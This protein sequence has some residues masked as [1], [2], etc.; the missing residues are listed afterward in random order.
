[1]PEL[2]ES[3]TALGVAWMRALHQVLDS[4]PLILEDEPIVKL[5]GRDH[6]ERASKATE[7]FQASGARMLR[8]HVVLRSRFTEDR[9]EQALGRGEL[10]NAR[11]FAG[12]ADALPP[13]RKTSLL[14]AIV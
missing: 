2:K 9:L 5:L 1:M 7:R 11:Y 3:R 6:V 14:S 4:K 13:P 10:A 8:S 12:R